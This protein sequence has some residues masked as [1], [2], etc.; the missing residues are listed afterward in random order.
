M[1]KKNSIKFALSLLASLIAFGAIGYHNLLGLDLIDSLYMTIITIS[2]VGY[3]EVGI[4]NDS[5]KLFSMLLIIISLGT[6]GYLFTSIV[7]SFLEG[8]L[9]MAW[10]KRKM[11]ARIEKL[12]NHYIV[13]GAGETGY[14]AIKQFRRRNVHFVVI[15]KDEAKVR[16]LIK[17]DILT[18]NGDATQDAVLKKANISEAKGLISSLSSDAD[19]VFTVLTARQMNSR[20]YIVSRAINKHAGEKLK[21]AGA[22]NTISPNE[23]G[24]TR[25]ASMM[26]RPNVISFLDII[27]RAGDVVLDLEDVLI[28]EGSSLINK[29]LKEAKIPEKTGLIVL[30]IRKNG[31]EN[32]SL[33]PSSDEILECGDTMIVLGKEDQ[34]KQ[35][36]SIAKDDGD[37]ELNFL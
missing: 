4:M 32:L 14:N 17:A 29:K 2:T 28:F 1:D 31:A 30:A 21:K 15:E 3:A 11:E 5:A 25:M 33:N 34:V 26:L 18:I 23:I 6:V 8:N 37:R 35:L 22:N 10:R 12:K 7:S 19:N 24:G 36:K 9:K 27:T 20:L 13:C 16:D